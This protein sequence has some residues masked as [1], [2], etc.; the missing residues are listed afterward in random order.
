M[1]DYL[2]KYK[3]ATVAELVTPFELEG[4]QFTSYHKDWWEGDAWVASKVIKAK[5]AGEARFEFMK[6]LIPQVEKCSVVSECAF[7]F[8]ANSYVIYKQTNNPEKI[9]Y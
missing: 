6:N 5:S 3:I 9:I 4:Y 7:R 1:N 8:V 2:I